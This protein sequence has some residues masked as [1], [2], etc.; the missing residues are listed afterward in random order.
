MSHQTV[1]DLLKKVETV[2]GDEEEYKALLAQRGSYAQGLLDLLQFLSVYPEVNSRLRSNILKTMLRLSSRSD[3]FPKCLAIR[4]VRTVGQY[5]VDGG[6]FGE[7]WKGMIG[8][9][10][11]IVCLKVVKVYQKSD[12]ELIVRDFLREAIIWQ[13]LEHPNLLPFLGLYCLDGR[14]ICLISPWM[15]TGNLIQ[16][17]RARSRAEVNHHSLVRD[18][19]SG[20]AH[21][22]DQK[23]VH[24]DLKGVNVLITPE[25]R[26]C[27]TD[28]GLSRVAESG[29]LWK[30]TSSRSNVGIGTTRWMAPELFNPSSP[31]T[32]ASDVYAFACVSYEIYTGLYPYYYIRND[33]AVMME[34]FQG[35]RPLRPNNTPELNDRIWS[36]M[37]SCWKADPDHRPT[38]DK[39]QQLLEGSDSPPQPRASWATAYW[40]KAVSSSIWTNLQQEEVTLQA[41]EFLSRS[42]AKIRERLPPDLD[43]G[44]EDSFEYRIRSWL[45]YV[46]TI[47]FPADLNDY[48]ARHT[49]MFCGR[50]QPTDHGEGYRTEMVAL[51]FDDHL[52]MAQQEDDMVYRV[53]DRPISLKLLD[54]ET[55]GVGSARPPYLR[56][57]QENG[58]AYRQW[59]L[60]PES[61]EICV[62]WRTALQYQIQ[63][64]NS[65][66]VFRLARSLHQGLL[67]EASCVRCSEYPLQDYGSDGPLIVISNPTLGIYFGFGSV[68]S[69]RF[70]LV[71]EVG[72][73][74]QC[75]IVEEMGLFL[76][77]A[78]RIVYGYRLDALVAA[79]R[80][81][82][83]E[84]LR[85]RQRLSDPSIE[86]FRVGK[87]M[88]KHIVA[89]CSTARSSSIGRRGSDPAERS[90]RYVHLLEPIPEEINSRAPLSECLERHGP[91]STWFRRF[92]SDGWPSQFFVADTITDIDFY[93]EAR[94][95]IVSPIVIREISPKAPNGRSYPMSHVVGDNSRLAKYD[96]IKVVRCGRDEYLVCFEAFGVYVNKMTWKPEPTDAYVEW[97]HGIEQVAIRPPYVLLFSRQGVEIRHTESGRLEQFI[98]GDKRYLGGCEGYGN[99]QPMIFGME[100]D[101][102]TE[103]N[104]SRLPFQL[105]P[106]F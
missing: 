48:R 13:Q 16:Y 15:E 37:Q 82:R 76:F 67:R 45:G 94:I 14:R 91:K 17:L 58:R 100:N 6:T 28:F 103:E 66:E 90:G 64:T 44:G 74:T 102:M 101:S 88:G 59:I 68:S 85:K 65:R 25:G 71:L 10:T 106:V 32:Y 26:A 12:V 84:P 19:A 40:H 77:M 20:L 62:I 69:A 78:D 9:S 38:A 89:L 105:E 46:P 60:L 30:I 7:I 79:A 73:V 27:I 72:D 49:L 61:E 51:L 2:L 53:R 104:A 81:G 1:E 23:I 56:I 34:I 55:S 42:A 52:I 8:H 80:S 31:A 41:D 11:Q 47:E 35:N 63:Q 36:I 95:V 29:E 50:L 5:A 87:Y 22:H 57:R 24:A 75:E 4:N 21:L 97:K 43:P 3:M 98:P 33:A 93:E 39:L 99:Q 18:V 54:F 96:P 83:M 86:F 92:R 70:K